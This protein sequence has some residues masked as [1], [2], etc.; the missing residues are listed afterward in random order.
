MT[1]D[2]QRAVDELEA[3]VHP[4]GRCAVCGGGQPYWKHTANETEYHPFTPPV[5]DE[6][7]H[8]AMCALG[9][10]EIDDGGLR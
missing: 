7:Q 6:H 10:C 9:W 4:E 3:I 1:R 8:S 5:E 2:I